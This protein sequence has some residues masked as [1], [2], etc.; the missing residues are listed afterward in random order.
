MRV[1]FENEKK[2]ADFSDG[3]TILQAAV[4]A[5]IRVNAPCGGR[6]QCRKCEALAN[7]EPVLMCET[8]CRDGMTVVT[9]VSGEDDILTK[10]ASLKKAVP[11]GLHKYVLA[12][13]TGT[14]TLVGYLLNGKTGEL[15]SE[16]GVLN[17]QIAFGADVIS[18][19][20]YA[21]EHGPGELSK[22]VKSGIS[23]IILK[24]CEKA[25]ISAEEI[26]CCAICGNTAMH[27]LL[28]EIDTSS[29]VTPPYNPSIKNAVTLKGSILPPL[30]S[31]AELRVLPNIAGF[32]GADTAA[33]ETALSFDTL[34][35]LSLMIDIGTNGEMVLG[36]KD[37][38]IACSTAAGPAFEGAKIECGM[39]GAKGA[40]NRVYI[41]DGEILAEVAGG[42]EAEGICGSGL[43]DLTAVL[44]EKGI[45]DESGA[46]DCEDKKF[47]I[48]G[49][50]VYI[51][52]K[53][54]R[55]VQLAKAAIRSGI[56]L[57]CEKY[58]CSVSDIKKVYVAG[59]FGNFCD[60]VSLCSIG[61]IPAEL[62]DKITPC[63][64][65]AGEGAKLCALNL[66]QFELSKNIAQNTGFLELAS[67]PDF[68]DVFV[69]ALEF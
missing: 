51:T 6:G 20:Q 69:D 31:Y 18:R 52:Q 54:V 45:I 46:L 44:L 29:L 47:V 15:L 67:M 17:P 30:S 38:R 13:D 50:K 10:G 43:I 58:G 60:P 24:C 49:T 11:D 19:I 48:P 14:T 53:D 28:L 61:L 7:G 1:Y 36:N 12:I 62:L 66:S 63:G 21:L 4:R 34:S 55:E 3:E 56:E 8:L 59:A 33:C 9:S 23:E 40:V 65:A 37:A 2:Y 42:G 26:T 68:Q 41:K 5:G 32:V 39:R 25:G 35:E 16:Y 27:H 57:L 64:N 22:A